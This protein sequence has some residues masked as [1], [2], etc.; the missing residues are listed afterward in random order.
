MSKKTFS[1]AP[2]PQQPSDDQIRAYEQGGVGHDA[3]LARTTPA[4]SMPVKR[5]SIDLPLTAHI[6]FKTAC[7]ATGRKMANELQLLIVQ[8]TT[9]MEQ[10]AGISLK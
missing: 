7:S 8:R 1:S 9:E 6:R 4:I 10:E 5:L 3:I 2:K